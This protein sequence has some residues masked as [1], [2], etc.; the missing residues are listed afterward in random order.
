MLVPLYEWRMSWAQLTDSVKPSSSYTTASLINEPPHDK[1]NKM[2]VRPAK[3]QISLGIRPVW[4]ES[5]LCAQWVAKDPSFLHADSEDSDQTG[6]MSRLI[7]F[8]AGR[9]CH[10]VGFVMRRLKFKTTDAYRWRHLQP[11]TWR[12]KMVYS[13]K[14]WSGKWVK[15]YESRSNCAIFGSK[16][17]QGCYKCFLEATK[18]YIAFHDIMSYVHKC[19]EFMNLIS[20][21]GHPENYSYWLELETALATMV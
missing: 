12:I 10:F 3:T 15:S 6:R 8:F 21:L 7:W 13:L 16:L 5:S 4:S 19:A 20:R 14:I 11:E 1:T 9:T 2:T 18:T 17:L